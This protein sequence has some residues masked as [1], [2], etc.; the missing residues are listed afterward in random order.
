M[1]FKPLPIW[2]QKTA[3]GYF[4]IDLSVDEEFQNEQSIQ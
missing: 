4:P 3:F 2:D 1:K